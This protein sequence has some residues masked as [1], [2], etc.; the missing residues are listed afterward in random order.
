[1]TESYVM[2]EAITIRL[3]KG[4]RRKLER[5]ARTEDLTVSQYVRRALD[6]EELLAA[7]EDARADLRRHARAK[8]IYTEEDVFK[9]VS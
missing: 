5:R 2:Q 6:A 4:T 9:M 8:G 7:F 3:P 1:M